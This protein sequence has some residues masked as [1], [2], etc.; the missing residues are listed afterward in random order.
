MPGP[1]KDGDTFADGVKLRIWRWED[2]PALL[3]ESQGSLKEGGRRARERGIRGCYTAGF[4]D[5]G[6][7]HSPG[8]AGSFQKMEKARKCTLSIVSGR[9]AVLRVT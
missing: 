2:A 8:D 1:V 6:R 9:I 5:G 7:G 4:E 3:G